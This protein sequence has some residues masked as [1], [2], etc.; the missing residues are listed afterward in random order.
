MEFVER[1]N[2]EK[3]NLTGNIFMY[4]DGSGFIK[5]F[6]RSAYML[7]Q[8]FKPMEALV[9]NNKDYGGLYV[10]IG[11]PKNSLSNYTHHPDYD[12]TKT[13]QEKVIVHTLK[14]KTSFSFPEDKFI[15]WKNRS[16]AKKNDK[17]EKIIELPEREKDTSV[18]INENSRRKE[19]QALL[20]IDDIM[21]QQLSNYTPMQAL[22]Y[23]NSLQER[24]R[25]EKLS[26]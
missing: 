17:Q 16:I 23:L 24:I 5:V 25:N 26:E 13:E 7:C 20:I 14:R 12:Y 6:E 1:L 22:N 3:E 11:F 21:S 2:N 9:Y 15:E 19:R 4:E 8:A 10:K 18:I